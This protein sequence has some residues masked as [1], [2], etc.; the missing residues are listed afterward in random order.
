MEYCW[1]KLDRTLTII[2]KRASNDNTESCE[3][4]LS[5]W[6]NSNSSRYPLSWEGVCELLCDI[7]QSS[8]AEKVKEAL[9]IL[10]LA[11]T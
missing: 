5:Q 1:E 6:I 4:V 9:I 8:T 7:E 10:S 3:N 2:Q 11:R